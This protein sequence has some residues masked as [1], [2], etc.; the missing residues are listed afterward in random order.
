MPIK[1]NFEDVIGEIDTEINKRRAKWNLTA[2]AWLDFD[3]VAQIIRFH[4]YKKWSLYKPEKA[5]APWVNTIISNQMRNLIRNNYGNYC[6][7]CTK[8]AAA[9]GGDLCAIYGKQCGD[10]PIYANWEKTKKSA[11]DAKLPVALENHTQ[12]VFNMSQ[13]SMDI[14]KTAQNLHEKMS[15]VLKPIEWKV[16][17]LLYIDHCSEE[18]VAKQMGYRTSEVGRKIGY[19]QIK[20]LKKSIMVKVKKC[21]ASG[22]IDIV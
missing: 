2:L 22:E 4:I 8:C 9:E 12:E 20:N 15:K 16:Y 17:R 10:C 5:L 11:Y 3:D 21:L 6:R 1:P 13:D 7:P 14:E 18:E 19:K